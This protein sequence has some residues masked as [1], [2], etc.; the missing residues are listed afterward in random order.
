MDASNF[1]FSRVGREK[2]GRGGEGR[3]VESVEQLSATGRRIE[4]EAVEVELCVDQ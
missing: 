1:E 3:S 2:R 4:F